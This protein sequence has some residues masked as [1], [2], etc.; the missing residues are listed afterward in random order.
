MAQQGWERQ[1]LAAL[2]TSN[3]A[4][5]QEFE[6]VN[7]FASIASETHTGLQELLLHRIIAGIDTVSAALE[8]LEVSSQAGWENYAP[9]ILAKIADTEAVLKDRPEL[10][11]YFR[12]LRESTGYTTYSIKDWCLLSDGTNIRSSGAP[13]W[14]KQT[15]CITDILP[16]TDLTNIGI[17]DVAA[18]VAHFFDADVRVY[19]IALMTFSQEH[20]SWANILHHVF[21]A[22]YL[23]L[24]STP[25]HVNDSFVEASPAAN[26]APNWH[27]VLNPAHRSW[28]IHEAHTGQE[29]YG[30]GSAKILDQISV[31]LALT[32]LLRE[33]INLSPVDS[34]LVKALI[35]SHP[36]WGFRHR[37]F[38]A[39][40]TSYQA[41]DVRALALGFLEQLPAS[42]RVTEFRSRLAMS[43]MPHT[44]DT[45]KS[46]SAVT[47][48]DGFYQQVI[49]A[50]QLF[51]QN[52]FSDVIVYIQEC[53]YGQE[54]LFRFLSNEAKA[55]LEL[56]EM[57]DTP[58][59]APTPNVERPDEILCV[60]HASVPDQTGGYAIRAHG[61]LRSLKEH[62]V[63]ISAVTR[64]G[65][66]AGTRTEPETVVVDDV[67]Y[68]RLPD[69]G[70][71][72]SHG[73]IQY[74]TSFIEPFRKL[75]EQQGI[76]TIHVRSTFLIALPALIA[77]RQL[78]LKVLY[79]VSG[80]WE[81]VYQDREGPSHLLKR[82]PFAE[83]AE[84]LTMT[85]ADQLVVMNEAVRQIA[86]DRGVPG[87]RI[88]V[89]ANAVDVDSFMPMALPENE[90]FTIG[91]LGSFADYEGL[92]DIVDVAH[93]LQQQGIQVHVL[94][95]GDGLRFNHIRSRIINEG[96]ADNFTLT[97]RIPHDEV[98]NQYRQM[99]LLVYPRH[100]TG[101][102]ETITPLKPFEALA[103]AKPIIVSDVQPLREIVGDN[104]R[105]LVFESG[106]VHDFARAI[107]EFA[108][109]PTSM[110]ALGAAGR[111][112][113]V[114][115]R[116]WDNVVQSF[117]TAYRRLG[118]SV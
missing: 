105:G 84:T 96:L 109:N 69:T 32:G 53:G 17:D 99:D 13:V 19:Q 90:T 20:E 98:M 31:L 40:R 46:A 76:G 75:F 38:S 14:T 70:I 61:V 116:N 22:P 91:Y 74:L 9:R 112:W 117:L 42:R 106:N 60:T 15:T 101:A 11:D 23:A 113:V 8:L 110:R 44:W 49:R 18:V 43:L 26:W 57:L 36:I 83:L 24:D 56:F 21:A 77:A 2:M 103:L 33:G 51:D 82:A 52:R 29:L 50:A 97:G 89:A 79:E 3:K 66:P 35:P 115:K 94:M 100:S 92:D 114:E 93:E 28:R 48:E 63:K 118:D 39:A 88:H 7:Y 104:E 10:A 95:V 87:E 80:L 111:E 73:E 55:A 102:T 54:P 85:N 58:P 6:T 27:I 71:T 78:G 72:R 37:E 81:L 65:F 108:M 47:S 16:D 1:Y 4:R 30:L 12:A 86:Q 5:V 62:G 59:A 107:Q 34:G 41:E 67:V 64:P 45:R 68:R 25:P